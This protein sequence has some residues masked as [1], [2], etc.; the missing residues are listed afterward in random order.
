MI[1]QELPN[2]HGKNHQCHGPH[3]CTNCVNARYFSSADRAM[4]SN[5]FFLFLLLVFQQGRTGRENSR[6]GQEKSPDC[7]TI[8]AGDYACKDANGPSEEK[9]ENELIPFRLTQSRKI[10][11]YIQ[12]EYL[13][14][15]NQ[16]PKETPSHTGIKVTVTNKLDA[17]RFISSQLAQVA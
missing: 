8:F 2:Y 16:S 5:F 1:R 15:Q 17:L 14:S 7:R 4:Q 12:C 11:A 10:D 3:R 6:E 13:N 9:T